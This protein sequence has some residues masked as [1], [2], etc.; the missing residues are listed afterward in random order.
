MFDKLFRPRAVVQCHLSSPLLQERLEYLQYCANQG[1]S[2]TTLRELAADLLLIQNLLGLARSTCSLGLAAVQAGVNRWV[3]RRPRPFNYKN[4]RRGRVQVLSRAVRWLRFLGR[5]RL[6]GEAPPAY[7]SL[8]EPFADYL[9]VEKG[10]SEETIRTRRWY[11]EDFLGWFLRDHNS[12]HQITIPDVDEAMARKGRDDGYARL[13]VRAYASSLR[14]FLRYAESRGWCPRGLAA[15]VASSRVYQHENLPVGPSWSDVQRLVATTE[16][17]R[18]K[19]IRDRAILLLL[20][21][22]ALRSGEVRALRLEDLD[23]EKGLLF[24]SRTK[25][26]KRE[27]Y[28]FSPTVGQAIIRY[29]REARPRSSYR[30]VFLTV[31]APIQPL[32]RSSLWTI[33]AKRTLSLDPPVERHGPHALRH[34]SA[35]HLLAQGFSLKEIGDH[36]GHRLSKTTAVYAKVNLTGLREVANL[37]LGGLL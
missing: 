10:L 26:R 17:S 23:W 4:G 14:A 27:P 12:L 29:L 36:L 9:R 21:V 35:T 2:L 30:E 11:V 15:F 37:S 32:R 33:V 19:D 24:V 28:P 16:G 6:P 18:P 5:L 20:A 22:Y 34:A 3:H 13:S 25:G 31:E 1:Y 7:R 8:L